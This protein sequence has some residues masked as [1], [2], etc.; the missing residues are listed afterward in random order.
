M[1]GLLDKIMS[2]IVALLAAFAFG[3]WKENIAAGFFMFFFTCL[4]EEWIDR[5]NGD[6]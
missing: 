2:F 5:V 3:I 6:D 1:N 4:C